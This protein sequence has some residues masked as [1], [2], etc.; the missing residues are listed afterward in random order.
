[1][2]VLSGIA[3][4]N[5][6]FFFTDVDERDREQFSICQKKARY[7]K[8][9][10]AMEECFKNYSLITSNDIQILKCLKPNSSNLAVA[11]MQKLIFDFV[12]GV[13]IATAGFNLYAAF[14]FITFQ[15]TLENLILANENKDLV[16]SDSDN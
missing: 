1:M 15:E 8:L 14:D 13:Y 10:T 4:I 5:S 7:D 3:L 6:F 12:F 9:E 2:L 11:M 16:L